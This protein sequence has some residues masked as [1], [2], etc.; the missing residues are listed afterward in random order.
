MRTF[1]TK[2]RDAG[3]ALKGNDIVSVFKHPKAPYRNVTRSMLDLAKQ[4]GG[5]RLDA[6]D[7]VLPHIY[8]QNGFRAV[9]RLPWNE[10]YKPEGWKHDTFK[11]HNGGRPDVVFMAHDPQAGAYQPTDGPHVAD[12]DAGTAAQHAALAHVQARGNVPAAPGPEAYG[13][14]QL[15]RMANPLTIHHGTPHQ[16]PPTRAN[17]L[18]E[19]NLSKMGTGEGA[20]AY[21]KG[22]YQAGNE[23]VAQGYRDDLSGG[24]KYQGARA[25]FSRDDPHAR[26]AHDVAEYMETNKLTPEQAIAEVE[27]EHKELA[28]YEGM[29]APGLSATHQEASR[30]RQQFHLGVHMAAQTL[31]P[32]HFTSDPGHLYEAELHIHPDHMLDWD[33]PLHQHSQYVQERLRPHVERAMELG[34]MTGMHPLTASGEE[35]HSAMQSLSPEFEAGGSGKAGAAKAL[36]DAGIPGIKYLDADSRRPA[37]DLAQ[38]E[39]MLNELHT[40]GAD[41]FRLGKQQ[42]YVDHLRSQVSHNYVVFDPR[43]INIVKRNGLPAMVDAGADALRDHKVGTP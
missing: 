37:R 29:P 9:A 39:A 31:K 30:R 8:A 12:Y 33:K 4:N 7:T 5:R 11:A 10:D 43:T 25:P 6:F 28:A 23:R 15:I 27:R 16:F 26:A 18:G 1:L 19:F 41:A 21:G 38:A 36:L 13:S 24:V 40:Q 34:H 22:I 14:G 35:V 3:F 2:E 20:Q 17:P 32:E 42:E